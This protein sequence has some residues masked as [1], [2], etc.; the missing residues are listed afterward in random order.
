M[1]DDVHG[2][3]ANYARAKGISLSAAL[4]ELLRKAETAGEPMPDIRQSPNG[5]PLFPPVSGEAPLT[6]KM[7]KKLEGQ[8]FEP[9][10]FA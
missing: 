2:F 3:V 10:T 7:V 6:D 9:R 4:S 8:E 1:D 5:F